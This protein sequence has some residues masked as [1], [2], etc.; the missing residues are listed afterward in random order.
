MY[1]SYQNL[2]IRILGFLTCEKTFKAIKFV[3]EIKT[4]PPKTV[5]IETDKIK[6][7]QIE[8]PRVFT[9]IPNHERID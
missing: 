8:N 7:F 9:Q 4:N 1:F 5:K 2:K 6:R 3:L